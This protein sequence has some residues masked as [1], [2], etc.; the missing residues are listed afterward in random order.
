MLTWPTFGE[1]L[2]E[3]RRQVGNLRRRAS[4]RQRV[5]L[6]PSAYDWLTVGLASAAGVDV[7]TTLTVSL[8]RRE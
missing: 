4:D 6:A 7:A 3:T 1:L 2:R 8:T 5:E